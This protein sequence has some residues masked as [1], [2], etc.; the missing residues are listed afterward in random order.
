MENKVFFKNGFWG[1][2]LFPPVIKALLIINVAIFLFEFLFL[3]IYHIEGVPLSRY[4]AKYF[5]LNPIQG[6]NFF[7]WQLITYQFIHGGIFHLF[8]NLFALWMFGIELESIWGSRKFLTFYLLSGIGAGL[9]QLFIAPIFSEP[10]PTIGA[11]GSVFGVLVAFGFTF[12]DRPVFMFPIFIPIPAKFFVIL[13]AGLAFILGITGSAG[14]VAHIAH[15]GGA[16]TGFFLLKFGD[17]IGLYSAVDR[18]TGGS[19]RHFEI[20]RRP[21][22]FIRKTTTPRRE[23]YEEDDIFE[24]Y[25]AKPK[26]TFFSFEGE[27]ITQ[28]VI[29]R[30]LDKISERGY[31]SLTEKEKRILLEL[32]KRL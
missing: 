31:Q 19:R 23:F 4:F 12:P 20:H 3:N 29:D 15:L 17:Q 24:V 25:D 26:R 9:F 8:F 2:A 1:G 32:S 16:I 10:L 27:E 5:Y 6:D 22:F 21:T 30:I 28:D 7:I 11:S 14:N 18:I 13:Y